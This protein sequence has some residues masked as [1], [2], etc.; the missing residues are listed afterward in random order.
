MIGH[1]Y[2]CDPADDG[3]GTALWTLHQ[4]SYSGGYFWDNN[5]EYP[6]TPQDYNGN[7][8]TPT[9]DTD[10]YAVFSDGLELVGTCPSGISVISGE[11]EHDDYVLGNYTQCAVGIP[12][13]DDDFVWA[14]RTC[15][16]IGHYVNYIRFFAPAATGDILISKNA[17]LA[18]FSADISAG[19]TLDIEYDGNADSSTITN[20]S[21]E[22]EITIGNFPAPVPER[23]Y[24]YWIGKIRNIQVS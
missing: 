9:F 5:N 14:Q 3:G 7:S 20:Y 6:L 21:Y 11:I 8:K 1:H 2:A 22:N 24:R 13:I 17:S 16:G 4:D 23:I 10:G 15:F 12:V 19:T 18:D